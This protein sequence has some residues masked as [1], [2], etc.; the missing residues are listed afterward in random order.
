MKEVRYFL[1]QVRHKVSDD[2]YEKGCVVK[3]TKDEA[4]GEG[5]AYASAYG[6]GR[7]AAYDYVYI[8]VNDSNG[9]VS[10]QPVVW[11]NRPE[12]EPEPQPEPEP[13][14]QEE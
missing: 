2:S 6:Y 14:P 5:Y 3:E 12:P 9:V 13:E 10:L 7:S 4:V 1:T 11:D 8:S